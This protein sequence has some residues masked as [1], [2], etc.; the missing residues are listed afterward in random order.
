VRLFP[1]IGVLVF[2]GG[3]QAV[4]SGP[5]GET[6]DQR[7][8]AAVLRADAPVVKALLDQGANPGAVTNTQDGI[9]PLM[10]AASGST[11]MPRPSQEP[12]FPSNVSGPDW[13]RDDRPVM[14][15]LASRGAKLDARDGLGRTP[16][17][18]SAVYSGKLTN[19]QFLLDHHA[20]ANPIDRFGSSPLVDLSLKSGDRIYP[21]LAALVAGGADVNARYP[22]G[23]P[24]LLRAA[25]WPT[26]DRVTLL[27]DAGA[28]IQA[29]DSDGMTALMAAVRSEHALMARMLLDKGARVNVEDNERETALI[30]AASR[31]PDAAPPLVRLLLDAGADAKGASGDYALENAAVN[32]DVDAIRMLLAAGANP[33]ALIRFNNPANDQ[34]VL[35][36]AS[37]SPRVE[38]LQLLLAAGARINAAQ[39]NGGTA[40]LWAVETKSNAAVI[41]FLLTSGA[42]ANARD[43][44]G[45]T[46]L[47][48][49]AANGYADNVRALL[50]GGADIS[51]KDNNGVTA[52]MFA[53]AQGHLD[54]VAILTKK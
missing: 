17:W 7:L 39:R 43:A 19:T 10:L 18:W 36:R 31:R 52:L 35:M 45:R 21:L 47:I 41:T 25:T 30:L 11:S 8:M 44:L 37:Q 6:L 9:T 12:G 4:L 23:T 48:K 15:L 28:D 32:G 1:L 53:Q 46:P 33:N 50:D 34:T 16:L 22:D 2:C 24:L 29:R 40:L 5:Q 51:L 42:N 13:Q 3:H 20:N 14:E 54:V 49:A 26:L 38:P 27:L